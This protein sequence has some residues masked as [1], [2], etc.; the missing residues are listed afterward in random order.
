MTMLAAA[1]SETWQMVEHVSLVATIVVA[2]TAWLTY[3][4]KKENVRVTPDPI[5]TR[6]V[7]EKATEENCKER[8]LS[9]M[10]AIET[11]ARENADEHKRLYDQIDVV[12]RRAE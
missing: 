6:R 10:E 3:R 4:R 5:R 12:E 11:I 9:C 8:H 7:Q 1:S 2:I